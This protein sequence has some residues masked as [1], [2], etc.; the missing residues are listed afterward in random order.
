M[1]RRYSSIEDRFIETLRYVEFHPTNSGV[2]SY[3]YA[4]LLRDIGSVFSSILDTFV[5]ETSEID[6]RKILDIRHYREFIIKEIDAVHDLGTGLK[7][8]PKTLVVVP[9][10]DIREGKL[11]WW[12]A[13]NSVKHSDIQDYTLGNLG[14]VLYGL[15]SLAILYRVMDHTGKPSGK[16]FG[17]IGYFPVEYYENIYQF[18]LEP[19]YGT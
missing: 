16:I 18:P 5:R 9:F 8:T 4:S 3:E 17:D 10:K 2:F 13:Y 14:N 7:N 6:E 19:M 1:K 12:D 15:A 11:S